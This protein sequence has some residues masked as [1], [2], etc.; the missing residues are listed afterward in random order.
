MKKAFTML[1]LIFVLIVIGILTAIII[2]STKRNPV[3]EAAIKLLSLIRYTQHLAMVDDKFNSNNAW[4]KNRWQI[5][6]SGNQ[7]SISS[8]NNATFAKN[9]QSTSDEIKNKILKG[10]TTITANNGCSLLSFDHVG[11]PLVGD[12]NSLTSAYSNSILL[13]TDCNIT[14][15]DASGTNRKIT[16]I[17]ET[18]YSSIHY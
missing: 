18:G 10:I 8:D 9:P 11:R 7:Y 1:E 6:F 13:T 14:I 3:D 17:P 16:I 2:P 15:T 5:T 12:L 4:Y